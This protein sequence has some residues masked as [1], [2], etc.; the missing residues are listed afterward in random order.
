[1][2]FRLILIAAI[3]FVHYSNAQSV[4]HYPNEK[5]F[6]NVRQLTSGGDNAEA[7][8]S[9]D[10]E[11]I[12]YQYT[13]AKDGINCDQIFYSGLKEFKPQLVSTGKGR[14]TCSHFLPGD[15]LILYASTHGKSD[16]CPPK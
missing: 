7:Y 15:S 1:M 5:H 4:I 16:S 11:R 6:K 9:F 14:T 3:L 10:S 2:K 8:F 12:V 13:N